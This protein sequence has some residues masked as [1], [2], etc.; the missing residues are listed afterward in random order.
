MGR[1]ALTQQEGN[2][3]WHLKPNQLLGASKVTDLRE[4]IIATF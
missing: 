1:K 4:P 3:S 2:C